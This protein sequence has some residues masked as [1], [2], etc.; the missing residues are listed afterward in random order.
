[1][2][3]LFAVPALLLAQDIEEVTVSSAFLDGDA[4]SIN[5]PI[6]VIQYS[7]FSKKGV[8]TLA[9]SID[10]LLGVSNQD[11]GASVGQPIIRGMSGNRV[12]VLNNGLVVRDVAFMGADHPSKLTSAAFNK[13]KL[14][15]DHHLFFI[16]MV[17]SVES[18]TS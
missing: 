6:H 10:T 11:Y 16:P 1:M 17:Q 12:K 7:D 8:S 2:T 15:K 4:S 13:L 3:A 9:E 18:L 14:L 5:N